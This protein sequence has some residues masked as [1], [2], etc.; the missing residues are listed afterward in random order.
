MLLIYYTD[1][2]SIS[3]TTS[4]INHFRL[5][6]PM[7]FLDLYIDV[8]S[9]ISKNLTNKMNISKIFMS[10]QYNLQKILSGEIA[11]DNGFNK[12]YKMSNIIK[13]QN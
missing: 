9:I 3:P 1:I 8:K 12:V 4:T 13:N 6:L 10:K 7:S 5:F 11:F 2:K